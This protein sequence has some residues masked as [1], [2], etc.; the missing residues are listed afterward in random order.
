[1]APH[2][3]SGRYVNYFND[4]EQDDV[5]A[6]AYG[7]NYPRLRAIKTKYDPENFFHLSQNIRPFA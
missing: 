7:L 3:A 4:D 1:M 5:V 2:M 6:A